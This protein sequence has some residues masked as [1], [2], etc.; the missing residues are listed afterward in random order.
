MYERIDRLLL[1]N[2]LNDTALIVVPSV[3]TDFRE[4]IVNN[5]GSIYHYAATSKARAYTSLGVA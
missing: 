3:K 1:E 2:G 4:F 5:N